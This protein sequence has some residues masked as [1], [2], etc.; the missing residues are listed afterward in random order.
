[1]TRPPIV[2]GRDCHDSA[3]CAGNPVY[4]DLVDYGLT[5]LADTRSAH[6]STVT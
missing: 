3:Q 6:G 4:G 5:M 2:D 1:M